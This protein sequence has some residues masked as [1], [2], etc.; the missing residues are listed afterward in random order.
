MPAEVSANGLKRRLAIRSDLGRDCM[1][2][3]LNRIL[4]RERV[5]REQTAT[6]S[7]A[8]QTPIVRIGEET[9][10]KLFR[11]VFDA[12]AREEHVLLIGPRGSGKS[13]AARM[14]I[15]MAETHKADAQA[16]LD[17]SLLVPGTQITAQGN[18][19]LPR[20]Y[21]FEPEFE[22][23]TADPADNSGSW[24]RSKQS[25]N[26]SMGLRSPPLF[27]FAET[28]SQGRVALE[29]VPPDSGG[30][31]MISRYRPRRLCHQVNGKTREIRR[32]VLFLDEINRFN[33]GVLDS[34]LLLLEERCVLFQGYLVQLPVVVVATMNP[35]GYDLSARSLSPPLLSRFNIVKQLYTAGPNTLVREILPK[36][37]GF[38][39]DQLDRLM[40]RHFAV[41]ILAFWGEVKSTKPSNAYIAP[42]AQRL[43][44]RISDAA[45]SG[46]RSDLSYVSDK[47]NYGPDARGARDWI[48]AVDRRLRREGRSLPLPQDR[49]PQADEQRAD[50]ARIA[51]EEL[52]DAIA[53]KLVLSFNPEAR[54]Q[55]FQKLMASLGRITFD[56]M[57]IDALDEIIMEELG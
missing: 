33:D 41:A 8:A 49:S 17:N 46:F 23:R 55:E 14:A 26:I 34:L 3:Y 10:E 20:D 45:S 12:I 40:F 42:N 6:L 37:L 29:S 21:F 54:P 5:V 1:L 35:P 51:V 53:N 47:S 25:N 22:F 7:G 27:R 43:L 52:G 39:A 15:T 18:K 19:E 9:S 38:N 32:F 30:R 48:L 16:D 50:L 57:T 13:Y 44:K 24:N 31:M 28:D 4:T 36:E 2:A 56:L 11:D